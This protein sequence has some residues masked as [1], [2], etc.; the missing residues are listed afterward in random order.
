MSIDDDFNDFD[1]FDEWFDNV[2]VYPVYTIQTK[3]EKPQPSKIFRLLRQPTDY[4]MTK[5]TRKLIQRIK[6]SFIL[7]QSHSKS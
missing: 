1:D 3:L 2:K 5:R 6:T 4:T 7:F